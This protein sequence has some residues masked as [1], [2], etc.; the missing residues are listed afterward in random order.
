[1]E[2][3]S[4][5]AADAIAGV[6]ALIAYERQILPFVRSEL[7]RWNGCAATIP[8]PVLRE[9]ALSALRD[10]GRNAEA[11]AVFAILA[12]RERRGGALR[13][14]TALQIA[15]DYLDSLGEA[16]VDDPLAD[17]LDLHRAIDD[18]VSPDTPTGDW[19]RRHPQREDGGY[20]AALVAACREEMAG[21]PA[22]GVAMPVLRRA[23]GR[24]GEGQSHTHA[25][26]RTGVAGLEAWASEQPAAPGY[27]WWEIAAGASS[28]VAVHALIAAA[29]DRR[30]TVGQSELIDALYFPSI[31]ALTVL[32][33]D[34][35]DRDDDLETGQHNY[36]DYYTGE[37]QAA[38]RIGL[39][40][41]RARAATKHVRGGRRHRAILAG[42]AAF[43]LSGPANGSGYARPIRERLLQSLDSPVRPIMLA[44][45]LRG[46]A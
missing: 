33:D 26:A 29:A 9:A 18:A 41:E 24:C 3:R 25:A 37:Q 4:G 10:K 43:F 5:S 40:A 38:D 12:P 27:L 17:G 32:L 1:V 15:I 13:A 46:N 19:Y 14:M 16:P 30:T 22:T 39:L 8:D 28:S 23:A 2:V 42:V 7:E 44:M 31:G 20:L 11:T 45:R 36:L 21:L 6:S 34:L 35:V